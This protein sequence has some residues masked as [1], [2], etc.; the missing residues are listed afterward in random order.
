MENDTYFFSSLSGAY[1]DNIYATNDYIIT[2]AS[3]NYFE[4]HHGHIS[5]VYHIPILSANLLSVAQLMNSKKTVEFWLD[6]FIVKDLS[7]CEEIVALGI[8][9][10][11]YGLCRFCDPL[12]NFFWTI[13]LNALVTQIDDRS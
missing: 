13:G 6:R 8:L 10:P 1:E 9:D 7:L 12:L 11:K 3:N 4:F 5:D 2:I